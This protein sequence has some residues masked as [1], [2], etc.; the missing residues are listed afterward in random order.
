M[1]TK[2]IYA[3]G[4]FFPDVPA[5]DL[6]EEDFAERAESWKAQG[7]TEA[8]LLQSGLYKK[9]ESTKEPKK[10]KKAGE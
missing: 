3:G 9:S 6:T 2:L 5:R 8:V 4:G 1:T 7:I 10:D